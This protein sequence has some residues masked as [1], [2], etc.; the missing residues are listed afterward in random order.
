[1]R[2]QCAAP[3]C[4]DAA[5]VRALLLRVQLTRLSGLVHL[6]VSSNC[7]SLLPESLAVLSGLTFLDASNNSR[8]ALPR[9]LS[10][11]GRL[12]QLNLSWVWSDLSLLWEAAP[13]LSSLGA[14]NVVGNGLTELPPSVGR[15]R[16]LRWLAG[17]WQL[18]GCWGD[19]VH[20]VRAHC[21]CMLPARRPPACP[22]ARPP[23]CCSCCC[24]VSHLAL[25]MN[26]L[27]SVPAALGQ[28]SR[29]ASLELS[30]NRLCSLPDAITSLSRLAS[31]GLRSNCLAG[32]PDGL[33]ALCALTHLDASMNHIR[34]RCGPCMH[35][36]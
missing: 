14:L 19:H 17:P 30:D 27:S 10:A 13:G 21:S 4:A 11:L 3:A 8:V 12:A 6:D 15:F 16:A 5:A 18:S 25:S 23:A 1:M 35:P 22:A 32:L 28:L 24:R 34:V 36:A 9:G 7:L 26:N 33:G 2:R 20:A 29:L 31:L